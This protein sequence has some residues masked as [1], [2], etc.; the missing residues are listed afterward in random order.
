MDQVNFE[1]MRAGA[2]SAAGTRRPRVLIAATLGWPSSARVAMAF[3]ELGWDVE[4]ICW[5]GN[6]VQYLRSAL[7]IHR[8]SPLRPVESLSDAILRVAPDL[9]VPC[10]DPAVNHLCEVYTILSAAG[11]PDPRLAIIGR[12]LGRPHLAASVLGRAAFIALARQE[13]VRAP[14]TVAIENIGECRKALNQIGFPAMLKIDSTWGGTGVAQLETMAASERWFIEKSQPIGG[15]FALKRLLLDRDPFWVPAW[16]RGVRP[17]L[18]VQS[19]VSGRPATCVVSCWEGEV[20]AIIQAEVL[21][22]TGTLGPSAVIRII[23]N[24]E[25]SEAARRLVRRLGISGFCGLDFV[26]QTGTNA[27][28]LIEMNQRITHLGHL[29]LG[30]GRDL[31]AALSARYTGRGPAYRPP[32]TTA[33]TIILFPQ[34]GLDSCQRPEP[35]TAYHDVPLAERGL[36]RELTR[37]PWR[38]R[39]WIARLARL[40]RTGS[41]KKAALV[42]WRHDIAKHGTGGLGLEACEKINTTGVIAEARR[43]PSETAIPLP[44]PIA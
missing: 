21:I 2:N 28:Y 29:A 11:R 35:E 30:V 26:I 41:S 32:V 24:P 23:D 20:L 36:I 14:T 10:D 16:L 18:N 44:C 9:V 7:R 12:S 15:L 37:L 33:D 1:S 3:Q 19:F 4:A 43:G 38:E 6:P 25:I 31:V 5:H 42:D 39:G 17:H 40:L 8:Y 22:S 13:G 34:A 27:P